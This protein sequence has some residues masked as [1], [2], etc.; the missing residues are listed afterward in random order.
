MCVGGCVRACVTRYAL[1]SPHVSTRHSSANRVSYDHH[2]HSLFAN[3]EEE[4]WKNRRTK[5]ARTWNNNTQLP[6]ARGPR[7]CGGGVTVYKC[8][9]SFQNRIFILPFE[10]FFFTCT[11]NVLLLNMC[12]FF[13]R[14]CAGKTVSQRIIMQQKEE[15]GKITKP[16]LYYHSHKRQQ[17]NKKRKQQ[18]SHLCS[19]I[20]PPVCSNES[21]E[22]LC[23]VVGEGRVPPGHGVDLL[24]V[25]GICCV[26]GK[27]SKAAARWLQQQ[28]EDVSSSNLVVCVRAL[29]LTKSSKLFFLSITS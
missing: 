7:P 24:S 14:P 29:D 3:R 2:S 11:S 26:L 18:T 8:Y 12:V 19:I 4:V 10:S 27:Q 13:D 22:K 5:C 23:W 25:C 17:E 15:N 9:C 6:P 16:L 20:F 21:E 28:R 1:W